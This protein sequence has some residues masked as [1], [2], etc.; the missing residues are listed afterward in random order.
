M[1]GDDTLADLADAVAAYQAAQLDAAAAVE[2]R[3]AAHRTHVDTIPLVGRVRV[4]AGDERTRKAHH[5]ACQ[6]VVSAELVVSRA[7]GA[8]VGAA[9]E[10]LAC[11]APGATPTGSGGAHGASGS[12]PATS[13][14]DR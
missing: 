7:A 10:H 3:R 12:N 5:L 1:T 13:G 8:V 9:V 14:G 2:S 4:G 6:Q 11:V